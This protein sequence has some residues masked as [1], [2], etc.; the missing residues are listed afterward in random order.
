MCVLF[1]A[2]GEPPLQLKG[3]SKTPVLAPGASTTVTFHLTA[4]SLSIWDVSTHAWAKQ[5]GK[6]IVHVGASSR[7]I[8][9]VTVLSV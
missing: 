4:R 9:L 1:G 2:A 5:S 8:R 3:F 7:D 6:F